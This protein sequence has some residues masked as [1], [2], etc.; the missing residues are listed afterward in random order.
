MLPEELAKKVKRI[1]ITTHR[2]INEVMTGQYR[3]HFKGQ[4]MQ[5][6]EHRTYVGGDD[7]RHIDWKASAR[8]KET[9]IKKY[10]EERE[11]KVFLIVDVS[12]SEQFGSGEKTKSDI[13]G[14]IGGMLAFAA[15]K[16]GDK[17]GAL[18][19]AGEVE[20]IIPPKRGQQHV[21]RVIREL[22]G[23]RSK[24]KGTNLKGALEAA[25]KMMKHGG[26]IF[27]LS[28]FLTTGY[29]Q[30]MR[31]LSLKHDVVAIQIQDRREKKSE[32]V[33]G[34]FLFYDPETGEEYWAD[35][36]SFSFQI[37]L[38]SEQQKFQKEYDQLKKRGRLEHLLLKTEEDY[39]EA[40]VQFFYARTHK[41]K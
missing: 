37:W 25:G 23:Y 34:R 1:Q 33:K 27:V 11:L 39:A 28:D 29:E 4:G 17:V 6:S 2:M 35:P 10:E 38:E 3:S 36:G 26:V 31:R 30:E 16:T 15:S 7:I 21:L 9:L 40:L 5:F 18:L 24:T 19:F 32:K 14:E 20:K 12:G 13:I 41:R 8:S 22:I